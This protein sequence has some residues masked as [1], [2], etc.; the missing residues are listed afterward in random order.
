MLDDSVPETFKRLTARYQRLS[1]NI[2]FAEGNTT[3]D[4]KAHR[5]LLRIQTYLADT[6]KTGSDIM[7]IGFADQHNV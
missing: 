3:L 7:L 5:D 1:V 6:G 2:R 4:N